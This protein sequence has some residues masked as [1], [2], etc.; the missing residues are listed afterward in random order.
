[1]SRFQL[2][3]VLKSLFNILITTVTQT[4]LLTIKS[5]IICQKLPKCFK[6]KNENTRTMREISSK[7]TIETTKRHCRSHVFIVNLL[8]A[9]PK[10]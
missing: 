1:M 10:K 5:Y 3:I 7:L 8:R 2:H 6:V 4:T 9:N